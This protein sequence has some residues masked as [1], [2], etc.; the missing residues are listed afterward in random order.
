[1]RAGGR[2]QTRK[3]GNALQAARKTRGRWGE[4]QLHNVME[5]SGMTA[6]VDYLPEKTVD[7]DDAR[8]RPDVI[9]RLPGD[10]RIVVDAKTAMAAYLD[11][12]EEPEEEA[13]QAPL[14]RA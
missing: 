1:M 6:Y 10:R 2:A 3:R 13:R 14:Q 5:L 4:Q 11:A 8:L 9:I 7:L 12:V